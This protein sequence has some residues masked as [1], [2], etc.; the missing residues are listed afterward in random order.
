MVQQNK[1]Y[2]EELQRQGKSLKEVVQ[3]TEKP[4]EDLSLPFFAAYKAKHLEDDDFFHTQ[5]LNE[6]V[7]EHLGRGQQAESILKTF[8]VE[9]QI[10]GPIDDSS[11]SKFDQLHVILSELDREEVNVQPALEWV[12]EMPSEKK[13]RQVEFHLKK[14]K[15]CTLL[16]QTVLL[17][18]SV[19][20][21]KPMEDTEMPEENKM[22]DT[23]EVQVKLP[24]LQDFQ[25]SSQACFGYARENFATF[26][27]ESENEDLR[28]QVVELMGALSFV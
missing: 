12:S 21:Q 3:T 9:S 25:Q 26:L 18:Q 5:H 23:C 17:W 20:E 10:K 8:V 24:T 11:Q 27:E 6:V 2:F 7:A 4:N 19:L 22:I 16:Q 1:D 15:Y 13:R 14:Y 28:N